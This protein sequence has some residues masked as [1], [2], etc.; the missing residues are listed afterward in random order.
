MPCVYDSYPNE[1]F[2]VLKVR[3]NNLTAMLCSTC[4]LLEEKKIKFPIATT[5]DKNETEVLLS[6]SS[7]WEAHK[8]R[9]KLIEK[10]EKEKARKLEIKA[11]ALAKLTAEE[12]KALNL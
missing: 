7:W 12:K 1:E 6:V 2:A 11:N 8:E 4:K 3:I 10:S 5:I 9:D